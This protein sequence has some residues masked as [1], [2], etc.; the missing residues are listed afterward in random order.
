MFILFLLSVFQYIFFQIHSRFVDMREQNTR[1]LT[2]E[3]SI[4]APEIKLDNSSIEPTKLPA[5][6]TYQY[7][8][9]VSNSL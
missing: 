3:G 1:Q 6:R 5:F 4:E 7:G 2:Y 8:S 9:R